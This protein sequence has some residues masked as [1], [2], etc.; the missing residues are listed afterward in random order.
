MLPR[1]AAETIRAWTRV[2][3]AESKG[4]GELHDLKPVASVITHELLMETRDAVADTPGLSGRE[5]QRL[6]PRVVASAVGGLLECDAAVATKIGKRLEHQAGRISDA[7]AA[8]SERAREARSSA[9]RLA[10][11][12]PADAVCQLPAELARICERAQLEKETELTEIYIGFN[13]LQQIEGAIDIA[14]LPNAPSAPGSPSAPTPRN[15]L[16]EYQ[17]PESPDEV[18]P[19]DD[20]SAW[21]KRDVSRHASEAAARAKMP[22]WDQGYA[23]G[24]AAGEDSARWQ[25]Q[26]ADRRSTNWQRYALGWMHEANAATCAAER[27]ESETRLK[28]RAEIEAEYEAKY[29][30]DIDRLTTI[31]AR[32]EDELQGMSE[33]LKDSQAR[34]GVLRDVIRENV[35]LSA[36]VWS[37]MGAL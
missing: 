26:A 29:E 6:L 17:L 30:G 37:G 31:I 19:P 24:R 25:V 9:Q 23:K 2:I 22:A 15:L 3:H 34:E 36:R 33:R 7:L 4:F 11:V 18:Q 5:R 16:A 12:S 13:E 21:T 32:L 28:V 35:M 14:A 20:V 8:I 10:H 27:A 1:Y